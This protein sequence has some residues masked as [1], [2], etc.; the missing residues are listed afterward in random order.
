MPELTRRSLVTCCIGG[1]AAVVG[2]CGSRTPGTPSTAGTASTSGAASPSGG[3]AAPLESLRLFVDGGF[4][5]A[6]LAF[7]IVPELTLT[8]DGRVLTSAPVP[9]IYPGPLILPL[10]ERSIDEA[11]RD[12]LADA[13]R[14][15]GLIDGRPPDFGTPGVA[16]APTTTLRVTL[17]GTTTTLAVNALQEAGDTGLTEEQ[18]AARAAL[19]YLVERLRD[20]ESTVGGDHLGPSRP[21]TPDGV[22]LRT[23]PFPQERIPEDPEPV[24]LPWTVAEVDLAGLDRPTLVEGDAA[25]AVL[26]T[27]EGAGELTRFRVPGNRPRDP[28]YEVLARPALPGDPPDGTL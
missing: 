12:A 10:D 11:G 5:T 13:V 16:D 8:P 3:P 22:W 1:F 2:G 14:A 7:R 24:V 28:V 4:T 23:V 26:A 19:Q 21:Y 25:D 17:G 15:S 6:A 18:R 20:L 9:A 27:L